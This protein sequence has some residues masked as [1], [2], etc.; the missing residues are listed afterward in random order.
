MRRT[1]RKTSGS[2]TRSGN[3]PQ[4]PIFPSGNRSSTPASR[5]DAPGASARSGGAVTVDAITFG[6]LPLD[7]F[8]LRATASVVAGDSVVVSAPTG[9]GKSAVG[10]TA[11][12]AALCAGR[13]AVYTTPLKALSNQKLK[14][15]QALFGTRRVGL[16]TGDV[17][18]NSENADV[19]IMTTEILRNMLYHVRDGGR[20]VRGRR[21]GDDR[22]EERVSSDARRGWSPRRRRGGRP[23]R[24]A[25][26]LRPRAGD[27]VGGDGHLLPARDPAR[28]PLGDGREPGRPRRVD[29]NRT[30][31]PPNR[32]ADGARRSFFGRSIAPNARC[33]VVAT[34][35][36]PVPLKWP[37][38]C[39]RTGGCGP[40]WGRC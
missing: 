22:V 19:V 31:Q 13:R 40:G 26:P 15:F 34:D 10:E 7:P 25:L 27:G 12:I 5:L 28:V 29:R 16:K 3:V 35:R 24:G 39:A 21:G 37:S 38:P 36:R 1:R 14:E 32:G 4:F 17:D 23:G 33:D 2:S 30:R 11:I 6:P 9:S 18:V 20:R 8:Q